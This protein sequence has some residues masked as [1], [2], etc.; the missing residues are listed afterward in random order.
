M[1]AG[2]GGGEGPGGE[3]KTNGVLLGLFDI[4]KRICVVR[5][6]DLVL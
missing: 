5:E 2:P 1:P 6:K 3:G 4:I